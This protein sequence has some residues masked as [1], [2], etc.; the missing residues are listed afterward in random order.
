MEFKGHGIISTCSVTRFGKHFSC[1]DPEESSTSKDSKAKLCNENKLTPGKVS[2]R[3]FNYKR[4]LKP[5]Y[6]TTHEIWVT[7]TFD[8]V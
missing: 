8:T 5:T 1:W 2:K 4:Y 7:M 3:S 6:L